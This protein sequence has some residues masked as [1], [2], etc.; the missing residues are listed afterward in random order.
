MKL[1]WCKPFFAIVMAAVSLA[2]PHS[3]RADFIVNGGFTNGL[4]GWSTNDSR[5]G[6]GERRRCHD[7][8]GS[9]N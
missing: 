1:K 7:F 8:R 5:R 9:I 4:S 6:Y 2:A 3:V